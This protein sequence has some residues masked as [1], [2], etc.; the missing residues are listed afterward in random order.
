MPTGRQRQESLPLSFNRPG[1]A[2]E[3]ASPLLPLFNSR[4]NIS[5]NIT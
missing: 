2:L 5:E 1:K 4:P 3:L